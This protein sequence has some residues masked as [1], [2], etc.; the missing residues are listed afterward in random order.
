MKPGMAK[1]SSKEHVK[2]AKKEGEDSVWVSTETIRYKILIS[3]VGYTVRA[4]ATLDN[5]RGYGNHK[6]ICFHSARWQIININNKDIIVLGTAAYIVKSCRFDA[7][8]RQSTSLSRYRSRWL[9]QLLYLYGHNI[10]T[11]HSS[12]VMAVEN[13]VNY[14]T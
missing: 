5:T 7:R 12:V 3:S 1:L 11:G 9:S 10:S 8:T 13:M 14:A 2:R 6:G 4:K